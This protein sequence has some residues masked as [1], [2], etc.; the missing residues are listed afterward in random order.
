MKDGYLNKCK[1]CSRKDSLPRNGK[2]KRVCLICSKQFNTNITEIKQGGGLCCSRK[3]F[4]KRLP[5]VIKRGEESPNWK[6][7]NISYSLVHRRIEY[8]LGKPR[9]CE[10]C[11]TTEAKFYD[12]ANISKKYK[13]EITDWKRLC[14]KCHIAYDGSSMKKHKMGIRIFDKV[15]SI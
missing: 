8:K 6:H 9:K 10:D 1:A 2:H 11:G 7:S 12:W 14:R 15:R 13:L 3:C 5:T 4:Y